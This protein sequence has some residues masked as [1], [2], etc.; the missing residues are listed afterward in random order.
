MT[1]RNTL[2][3]QLIGYY[4]DAMEDGKQ[5]HG[6]SVM[7]YARDIRRTIVKTGAVTLLDYGCGQGLQYHKDYNF[8]IKLHVPMPTLYDPSMS[9][10]NIKPTG[11]FDGVLCS[12]VLEHV[13]EELVDNVIQ[14]LFDYST[15]FVW[16]S[17]CCRPAKK[18][19]PDGRNMHVTIHTPE[20]WGAKVKAL[21]GGKYYEL[22]IA[23]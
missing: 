21:S 9:G 11:T 19:F 2:D 17:V 6:L 22:M 15:K 5:F 8:H 18:R 23:P 10:I 1:G 16:M 4:R 12:D 14:E 3:E 13:P 7:K 20:W